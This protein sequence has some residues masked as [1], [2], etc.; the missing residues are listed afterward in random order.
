MLK[1]RLFL[2]L[3]VL[4]PLLGFAQAKSVCRTSLRLVVRPNLM[5]IGQCIMSM[6]MKKLG[7]TMPRQVIIA[8]FLP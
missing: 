1:R 8:A 4:L 3:A 2:L 5:P 6:A 7:S